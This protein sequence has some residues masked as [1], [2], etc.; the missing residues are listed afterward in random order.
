MRGRIAWSQPSKHTFIQRHYRA[1]GGVQADCCDA[2][3]GHA[4]RRHR[5]LDRCTESCPPV[6]RVLLCPA[7]VREVGGVGT[8]GEGQRVACNAQQGVSHP[9][10]D[11]VLGL[12]SAGGV[13]DLTSQVEDA[14]PQGL[15][16][17]IHPNEVL[18]LG[19]CHPKR[20]GGSRGEGGC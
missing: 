9:D 3:A 5:C 1:V 8:A 11:Q 12:R 15:C 6:R 2:G 18:L 16:A 20:G 13:Q 14:R 4:R 17:S 19:C 10:P 7:G